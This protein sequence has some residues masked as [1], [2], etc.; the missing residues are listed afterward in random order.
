MTQI[1]AGFSHSLAVT[2]SGQLFAFGKNYYGQLGSATNNGTTNPNPTP[3]LVPSDGDDGRRHDLRRRGRAH[4]GADR[5]PRG[6]EQL[7]AE[8]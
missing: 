1:G 5:K 7:A 8:R 3:A 6:Y 2:S 4:A